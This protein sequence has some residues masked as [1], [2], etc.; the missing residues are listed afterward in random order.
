MQEAQTLQISGWDKR[1]CERSFDCDFENEVLEL[2]HREIQ[3]QSAA[4]Y[5]LMHG[6]ES[7]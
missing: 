1:Q 2:F 6:C 5:Q 3:G 4:V 7:V